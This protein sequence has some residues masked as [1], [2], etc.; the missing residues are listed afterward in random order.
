MAK[1]RAKKRTTKA[2][3]VQQPKSELPDPRAVHELLGLPGPYDP[4]P[5]PLKLTN[6][7]TFWDPGCSI[8]TL[9]K[10]QPALFYLRDFPER[11][12]MDTDSWRWKQLKLL[13]VEP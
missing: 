4:P 11:F 7:V 9:V 12:A 5:P 13:A 6:F 1:A 2:E 3:P 10:K 8:Q